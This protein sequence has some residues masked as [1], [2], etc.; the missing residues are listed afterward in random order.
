VV[1]VLVDVLKIGTAVWSRLNCSRIS[2]WC[3]KFYIVSTG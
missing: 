1:V 3:K 2:C